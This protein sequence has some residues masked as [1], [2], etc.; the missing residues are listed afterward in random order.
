MHLDGDSMGEVFQG[1]IGKS[2][3]LF[4]LQRF[5]HVTK[6]L[7]TFALK[8]V[9]RIVEDECGGELI[10]AGGDDVLAFLPTET[11]IECARELRRAFGQALGKQATLSSGIAVVHY[12]EDL[13]FAL[14]QV[15]GAEKKA[16]QIGKAHGDKDTKDALALT[17][18]KR[19]G[20]HCTVVMGWPEAEKLQPL[21]AAFVAKASDRWAY[22][23]REEVERLT[24]PADRAKAAWNATPGML[25]AL[26]RAEAMRLVGRGEFGGTVEKEAFEQVIRELFGAY[27][28]EMQVRTNDED[29]IA[30]NWPDADVLTGFVA[31][32]QSA[33]FLA[34]GK[35]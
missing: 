33:S 27:Q 8:D 20:E 22:K 15:R 5:R 17:I 25:L 9:K 32:C 24:Q 34:R 10:Y 11:V 3:K 23:L 35:E 28:Q 2:L 29:K 26:G 4:G 12:K 13:R 30:R 31:L 6:Q 1:D 19:S 14:G 7:T 21:V 18:C 16:K